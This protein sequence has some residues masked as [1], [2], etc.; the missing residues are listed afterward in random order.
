M[1]LDTITGEQAKPLPI[2]WDGH[3]VRWEQQPDLGI[4]RMCV[5]DDGHPVE[6]HLPEHCAACGVVTARRH[7]VGIVHPLPGDLMTTECTTRSGRTYLA[8][9]P[10]RV[11]ERRLHLSR[12]P[13]C[14]HDTVWDARTDLVWDLEPD[15]YGPDGSW[16]SKEETR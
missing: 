11:P 6:P 16:E 13:E 15:D 10:A 4:L 1:T 3:L 2:A 12:C 8:D 9:R 7:W 5:V 14:G